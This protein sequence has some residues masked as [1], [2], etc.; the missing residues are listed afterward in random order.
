MT[1]ESVPTDKTALGMAAVC[2]NRKDALAN[3]PKPVR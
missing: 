1:P 2:A 3:F